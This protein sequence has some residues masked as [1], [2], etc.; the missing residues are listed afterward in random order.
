[1]STLALW[2]LTTLL[3]TALVGLPVLGWLDRR[4]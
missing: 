2:L 4:R 3:G 1:M